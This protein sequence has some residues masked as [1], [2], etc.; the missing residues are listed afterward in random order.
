MNFADGLLVSCAIYHFGITKSNL[1][2][3]MGH[4]YLI[5]FFGLEDFIISLLLLHF[6]DQESNPDP[7]Y[8]RNRFRNRIPLIL[9]EMVPEPGNWF[10]VWN[11]IHPLTNSSSTIGDPDQN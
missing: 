5:N 7:S 6:P 8:K 4:G 9:P 10:Q 3:T 2:V 11:W 1:L